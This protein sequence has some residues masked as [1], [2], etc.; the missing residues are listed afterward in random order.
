MTSEEP[1]D[2]QQL[3]QQLHKEY[4]Q[5]STTKNDF[6]YRKEI[7]QQIL[8]AFQTTSDYMMETIRKKQLRIDKQTM[9]QF[10]EKKK[11][12]QH[13]SEN[14]IPTNQQ[15]VFNLHH[16]I[17][18]LEWNINKL[19]QQNEQ[20]QNNYTQLQVL[21]Q[22][23]QIILN[24]KNMEKNEQYELL[25]ELVEEKIES[26][27]NETNSIQSDITEIENKIEYEQFYNENIQKKY[28]EKLQLKNLTDEVKKFVN[29]I[30]HETHID[31]ETCNSL[32]N[33]VT[34]NLREIN[35]E[36]QSYIEYQES[37]MSEYENEN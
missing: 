22:T 20:M 36:D 12:L 5:H 1:I 26:V 32:I 23:N 8:R 27:K 18:Q 2:Y 6:E 31:N 19:T 29:E 9:K 34:N 37:I 10:N 13:I 17:Q 28:N 25:K 30:K 14:E 4:H 33:K 35:E 24:N 7:H 15:N 16:D 21:Y 3:C 11:I